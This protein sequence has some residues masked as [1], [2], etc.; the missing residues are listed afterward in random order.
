MNTAAADNSMMYNTFNNNSAPR[1]GL[2]MPDNGEVIGMIV[3]IVV[4]LV[5]WVY[6]PEP[7]L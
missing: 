2:R 6:F 7:S 4:V 3:F 5:V 1:Q